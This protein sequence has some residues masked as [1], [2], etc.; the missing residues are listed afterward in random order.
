LTAGA[1]VQQ[2]FNNG[3]LMAF[4]LVALL[5]LGIPAR[6][7]QDTITTPETSGQN[8]EAGA[9]SNPVSGSETQDTLDA[10]EI[11]GITPVADPEEDPPF[12]QPDE[13]FIFSTQV[14]DR[15]TIV[16]RWRIADTYYLYRKKFKFTLPDASGFRLENVLLPSGKI[17][18]DPYFGRVEVY[19]KDAEAVI[20][21]KQNTNNA[22]DVKIEIGYQGCTELGLCYPPITRKISLSLPPATE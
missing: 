12:L 19:F 21:L 18:T 14:L 11:L 5:G 22:T 8:S 7:T 16:A 1:S 9:L 2:P 20:N 4:C 15:Y 3:W 17:K 10:L 6:A 13:A